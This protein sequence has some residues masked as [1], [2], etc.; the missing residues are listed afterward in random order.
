MGTPASRTIFNPSPTDHAAALVVAAGAA[1]RRP[2]VRTY[3]C[4]HQSL[5][6]F[7]GRT[8]LY[9]WADGKITMTS[10][11]RRSDMA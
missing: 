7:R 11:R 3:L 4:A 2:L 9:E 10:V 8:R 1:I 6:E 5:T